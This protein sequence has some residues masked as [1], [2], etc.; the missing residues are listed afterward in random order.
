MYIQMNSKG[1]DF[2]GVREWC[3]G[4]GKLLSGNF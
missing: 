1:C 3:H 2:T 4:E